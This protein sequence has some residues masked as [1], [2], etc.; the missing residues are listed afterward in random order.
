MQSFFKVK[1]TS[2][3]FFKYSFCSFLGSFW[4]SHNANV[5]LIESPLLSSPLPFLF[6]LLLRLDMFNCS[7]FKF[8]D[9]AF[10]LLNLICNLSTEFFILA[11]LLSSSHVLFGS[12]F[13]KIFFIC[14]LRVSIC[15]YII[16]LVFLSFLSMV[17]LHSLSILK[18]VNLCPVSS[19]S[20]FP[21]NGFANFFFFLGMAHN[22]LFVLF[23]F[24]SLL[25]LVPEGYV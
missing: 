9:S 21:Q 8:V 19:I 15:L 12:F 17:S 11:I 7:I 3:Y 5:S 24:V 22:F 6:F 16:L 18:D 2:S 20:G 14:L 23:A 1:K 4:D 10:F 25:S 13:N